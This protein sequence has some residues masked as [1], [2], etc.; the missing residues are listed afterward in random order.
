MKLNGSFNS[1]P[2]I[3]REAYLS[4]VNG[5]ACCLATYY[6]TMQDSFQVVQSYN[7][8]LSYTRVVLRK[9]S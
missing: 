8:T 9:S 3:I 5:L 6:Y 4:R 1:S 7:Q 2:T